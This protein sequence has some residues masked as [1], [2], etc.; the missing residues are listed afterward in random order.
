M[1]LIPLGKT[2]S[3]QKTSSL[4]ITSIQI[5]FFC[6]C[7][8]N[9]MVILCGYFWF[10]QLTWGHLTF[11]M[12]CELKGT[13]ELIK[14][15]FRETESGTRPK[16]TAS[17]SWICFWQELSNGATGTALK[18]AEETRYKTRLAEPLALFS[19]LIRRCKFPRSAARLIITLTVAAISPVLLPKPYWYIQR[20]TKTLN[21]GPDLP[22][23]AGG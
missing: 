11:R 2:E 1:G 6:A 7:A 21:E 10:M 8:L 4:R 17:C 22:I 16:K 19:G 18:A 3:I 23:L 5:M 15:T 12:G 14:G 13:V 20:T 9:F